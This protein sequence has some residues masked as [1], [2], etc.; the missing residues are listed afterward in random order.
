MVWRVT[1]TLSASSCCVI[2]LFM[3]RKVFKLFFSSLN[4]TSLVRRTLISLIVN[5][6]I[7][8]V[9]YY[10]HRFPT[11]WGRRPISVIIRISAQ[12]FNPPNPFNL[13]F[14]P[15]LPR[16]LGEATPKA[17]FQPRAVMLRGP[18]SNAESSKHPGT[19]S[20]IRHRLPVEGE[21]PAPFFCTAIGFVLVIYDLL[22]QAANRDLPAEHS[23]QQHDV[24]EQRENGPARE[25]DDL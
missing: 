13:R 7:Q 19:Q 23:P 1:D 3:N 2:W 4:V 8:N 20:S 18:F 17:R 6:N 22:A 15:P 10:L 5:N 25:P 24:H 9:K 14:S 11:A 12:R 21:E 16:L